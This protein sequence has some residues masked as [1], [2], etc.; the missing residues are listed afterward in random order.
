MFRPHVGEGAV[1]NLAGEPFQRDRARRRTPDGARLAHQARAQ[2]NI[3]QMLLALEELRALGQLDPNLVVVRFGHAT[4]ATPAQVARMKSLGVLAE[5]NLGSNVRTGS[6]DQTVGGVDGRTSPLEQ[7]DDHVF[8]TAIYDGLDTL[9]STDAHDVMR[10][11]MRE[12]YLRAY[13]LIEEV[14]AG[15]RKVRVRATDAGDRG[16]P[17]EGAA[18][19]RWLAIEDMTADERSRFLHAYE[20]L[21]AD[22]RAYH[23]HRPRPDGTAGTPG[24]EDHWL[25]AAHA[26]GL[27]P[28]GV[29]R[30]D[31][32]RAQVV[33]AAEA[34]RKERNLVMY[35][36]SAV[37]EL[38]VRVTTADGRAEIELREVPAASIGAA[39]E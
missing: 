1:D 27:R 4:M 10:T 31:G 29:G 22:A 11:T 35:D 16:T 2:H 21:Y 26:H 7:Y 33:A 12:E 36:E 15:E 38:R 9:L 14:L 5:I 20:K 32:S 39:H 24:L 30:F 3:E 28:T 34:Y 13:R 23:Q 6:A 8:G 19:E 17:V 25:H 37:G 18:D